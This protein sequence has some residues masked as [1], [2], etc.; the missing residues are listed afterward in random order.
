LEKRKEEMRRCFKK[1]KK[2]F[3]FWLV[4]EVNEKLGN[5]YKPTI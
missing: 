4:I 5:S 2:E 1:K 3:A